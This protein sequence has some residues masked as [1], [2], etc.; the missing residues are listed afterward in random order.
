MVRRSRMQAGLG[1]KTMAA[2]QRHEYAVKRGNDVGLKSEPIA[3][4][5]RSGRLILTLKVI[6]LVMQSR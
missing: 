5:A 6:M 4:E 3:V 1:G 2:W